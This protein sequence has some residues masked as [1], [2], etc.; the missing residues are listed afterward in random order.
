MIGK[1]GLILAIVTIAALC[2]R[3]LVTRIQLG[4]WVI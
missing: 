2:I 4:G 3:W 1:I